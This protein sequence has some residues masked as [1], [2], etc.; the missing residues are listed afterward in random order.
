MQNV[1]FD[2]RVVRPP[3]DS[4]VR[5]AAAA[6]TLLEGKTS[7]DR[8]VLIVRLS[9]VAPLEAEATEVVSRVVPRGAEGRGAERRQRSRA[10]IGPD[11]PSKVV[12]AALAIPRMLR[13]PGRHGRIA[14]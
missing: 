2:T 1:P 14:V 9:A 3:V 11:L 13:T 7:G 4:D 5:E 10:L 8:S 12:R 6:S